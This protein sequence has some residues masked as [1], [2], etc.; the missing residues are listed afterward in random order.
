MLNSI[1]FQGFP[2]L[3]KSS[4]TIIFWQKAANQPAGAPT[5]SASSSRSSF[6]SRAEQACKKQTFPRPWI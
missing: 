1:S 6:C 4:F 2:L 3:N 5:D